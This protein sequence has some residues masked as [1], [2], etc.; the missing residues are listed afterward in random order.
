MKLAGH[1]MLISAVLT[2]GACA[3]NGY[4][5][6][7]QP[8]QKAP[9]VPALKSAGELKVPESAGALKIPPPPAT[10]VPFGE[11]AKDKDGD[12]EIHCLDKPPQM[13][14]AAETIAPAPVPAVPPPPK[15]VDVPTPPE[16]VPAQ[17]APKPALP[18]KKKKKSAVP[19]PAPKS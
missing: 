18:K 13:V 6:G 17:P 16:A 19:A 11:V 9:S 7:E 10:P 12:D 3:A 5:T 15:P 1:L 4:C 8:Y 2:L 14:A